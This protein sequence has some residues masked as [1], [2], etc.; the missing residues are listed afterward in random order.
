MDE[1]NEK[2]K[3]NLD[4]INNLIKQQQPFLAIC[5]GHQLL[6]KALNILLAKKNFPQQG[7]QEEINFFN[8]NYKVGFYNTFTAK[9]VQDIDNIDISYEKNT[10]E[11]YGLKSHFFQ[12]YQFHFESILTQ[13]GYSILKNSLMEILK[14]K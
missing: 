14:R 10:S 12:S 7:I 13:D 1:H 3:R 5:L 11:V 8:K 2:M 4:T 6:C 9:F